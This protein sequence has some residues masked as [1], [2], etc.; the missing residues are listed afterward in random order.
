MAPVHGQMIEPGEFRRVL[1]HFPSGV[2]IV[3]ARAPDGF[4]CGLTVNAFCSVSLEP[5][6]VLVCVDRAADS[7]SCIRAAGHFA[8]NVLPQDRGARLSRRFAV[9]EHGDKFH[10]LAYRTDTTGAPLLDDALAWLDCR[11][12]ETVEAGDHTVFFGE[13]LAADAREGLPLV[14]YRGGYGRFVP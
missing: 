2:V 3:T 9:G 1:G 13:V 8:V 12:T 7:N 14:Y 6:L 4:P 11:V 5:P 10:G